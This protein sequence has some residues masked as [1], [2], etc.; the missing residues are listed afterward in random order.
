MDN[1]NLNDFSSYKP[2]GASFCVDANVGLIFDTLNPEF[3]MTYKNS[4]GRSKKRRYRALIKTVGFKF[5]LGT[6][7]FNFVFFTD[8]TNDYDE[9]NKILKLDQGIEIGLTAGPGVGV[10]Y[11]PFTN[12]PGGLLIVG[13]SI[14]LGGDGFCLVTGGTLTPVDDT[15]L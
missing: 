12:A 4:S 8:S 15:D 5:D 3:V 14:G 1:V 9:S 13:W 7:R 6:I 10:I 2:T 11:A